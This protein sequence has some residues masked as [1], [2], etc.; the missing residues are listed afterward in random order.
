MADKPTLRVAAVGLGW[1]TMNRHI[2]AV[3]HSS[4]SRL[5]GVIDHQPSR[6]E[7]VARRWQVPLWATADDASDIAWLDQVDA[8]TIGTPPSTHYALARSY[9]EAGKHVLVEKPMAMTVDEGRSL[10]ELAAK[11]G[12]VLAV[13]HNFQF[14]RSIRGALDALKTGRLGEMQAIWAVQLSNPKRRLPVWYDQL[15]LGLFY[16]ESPHFFYLL[17][18]L[19]PSDPV[20][21]SITV[22]PGPPGINT[23]AKVSAQLRSREVAIQVD[24]NFQAPLSEWHI[25]LFGAEQAAF[26]DVFRDI[27]IVVPNDRKHLGRDILRTSL[28]TGWGHLVGT[29]R[30]GVRVSSGHLDYGNNEVMRR[31]CKAC[32]GYEDELSGISSLDGLAVVE[33]QHRVIDASR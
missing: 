17:R 21:E 23:P 20:F 28:V 29:I 2:P 10:S 5:V 11:R 9:L 27:L 22:V 31:F 18:A 13:V 30:S 16:D 25:G 4:Q 32:Q 19:T 3:R 15:P 7:L 26:I 24:M 33:M 14:A 8:V 12:R 1:V 6:A